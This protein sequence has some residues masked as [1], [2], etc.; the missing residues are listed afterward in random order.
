MNSRSMDVSSTE[1]RRR[2]GALA[3]L[4]ALLAACHHR[5]HWI[6]VDARCHQA[7]R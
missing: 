6:P 4:L 3:L 2:A 1:G 5:T 7:P